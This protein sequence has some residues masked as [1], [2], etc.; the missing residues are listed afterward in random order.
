[1]SFYSRLFGRHLCHRNSK[2]D[3]PIGHNGRDL[4]KAVGLATRKTEGHP[5]R[6]PGIEEKKN[7][8]VNISNFDKLGFKLFYIEMDH[9]KS[10]HEA[11]R[12]V[13]I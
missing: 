4:R 5:S 8:N 13:I 11:L 7:H 3:I 12:H 9:R 10:W 2:K 1:L 6:I